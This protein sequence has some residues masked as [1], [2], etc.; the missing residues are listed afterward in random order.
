MHAVSRLSRQ[1]HCPLRPTCLVAL[2][3]S[4]NFLQEVSFF[5]KEENSSGALSSR[6]STDTA[7]IRGAVGD[8]LGLLC[9]NLVT[10]AAG[11]II[12]FINGHAPSLFS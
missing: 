6:L 8:Q 11:Y 7:S 4:C 10:F 12:A 2:T 9:Q 1:A 5:D 3:G